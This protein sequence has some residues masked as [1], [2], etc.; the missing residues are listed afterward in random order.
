MLYFMM[1]LFS[2]VDLSVSHIVK[3]ALGD[4]EFYVGN[5]VQACSLAVC[6]FAVIGCDQQLG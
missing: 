4:W 3:Y 6:D 1:Y 2:G 5:E